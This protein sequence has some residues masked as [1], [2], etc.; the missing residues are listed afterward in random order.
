[1]GLIL[2]WALHHAYRLSFQLKSQYGRPNTFK[3]LFGA[4]LICKNQSLLLK[5]NCLS[6]GKLAEWLVFDKAN[7]G[8]N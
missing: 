8:Q 1:M 7:K 4:M 6:E 3:I 5:N 2:S